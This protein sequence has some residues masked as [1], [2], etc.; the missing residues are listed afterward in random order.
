MAKVIVKNDGDL[1][2]D[3][4]DGEK[5]EHIEGKCTVL[6]ACKSASCGSCLVK[7]VEGK[8]NLEAPSEQEKIGLEAFST[9]PEQRLCCQAKIKKGT[10][11][12]EY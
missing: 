7:V 12:I 3:V 6:F 1:E 4:P 8:E 10:V 11:K 9:L 2:V 5:L